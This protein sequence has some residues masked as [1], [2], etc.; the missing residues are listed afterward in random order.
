[1]QKLKIYLKMKFKIKN[2]EIQEIIKG[3]IID[4]PK[5]TRNKTKSCRTIK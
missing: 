2:N 4:F 1:M 5:F 3:E